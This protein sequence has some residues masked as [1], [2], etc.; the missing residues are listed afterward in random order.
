MQP[1]LK[2]MEVFPEEDRK[3]SSITVIALKETPGDLEF[4]K[5]YPAQN[6]FTKTLYFHNTK[7]KTKDFMGALA[8]EKL[9]NVNAMM[10]SSSYLAVYN[11][12]RPDEEQHNLA[13]TY[14]RS[15][16]G[17]GKNLPQYG[18]VVVG[19]WS[20]KPRSSFPCD[21]V[22]DIDK[23]VTEDMNAIAIQNLGRVIPKDR[24]GERWSRGAP[25]GYHR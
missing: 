4:W 17:R 10:L 24:R 12:D 23:L 7:T 21:D 22:D 18:I 11:W 25:I 14:P 3:V 6:L 16:L 15:P 8:E 13:I 9:R 5:Q 2:V 20:Y 19:A 1:G